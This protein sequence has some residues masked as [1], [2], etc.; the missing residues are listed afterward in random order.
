MI[1]G[2][3]LRKLS[4]QL[5]GYWR[6]NTIYS[7]VKLLLENWRKYLAEEDESADKIFTLISNANGEMA[8]ELILAL[9]VDVDEEFFEKYYEYALGLIRQIDPGST[10]QKFW[11]WDD[12]IFKGDLKHEAWKKFE[13]LTLGLMGLLGSKKWFVMMRSTDGKGAASGPDRGKGFGNLDNYKDATA[14][15]A[16]AWRDSLDETPT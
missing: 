8:R 5:N 12:L 10:D 2:I 1:E 6:Y 14:R 15:W 7:V 3:V 13:N 9:Q 11:K 16:R 4:I